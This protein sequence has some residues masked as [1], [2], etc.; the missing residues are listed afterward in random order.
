MTP[1]ELAELKEV[2]SKAAEGI[3]LRL[4]ESLN[5][6]IES[7]DGKIAST[8]AAAEETQ[9]KAKMAMEAV[10][11][12]IKEQI[13][14]QL[15]ANLKGIVAEVGAQFEEKMK[16]AGG[17]GTGA[18]GGPITL[19]K[20][21]QNSDKIVNVVNAFRSPTTDQAMMGQMNFVMKWHQ[22]LS[23]LEKGGGTG[24]EFTKAIADTFTQ[25]T[26]E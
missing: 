7:L 11:N 25:Q 6:A 2:V 16:A 20:L 12:L 21:L 4:F 8:T 19:D 1:E 17:A 10:P 5:K 3:E 26:Q 23:K 24:D 13:E 22:L 18:D 9:S 14:A 15:T